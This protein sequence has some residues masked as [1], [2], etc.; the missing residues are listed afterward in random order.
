MTNP[1]QQIKDKREAIERQRVESKLK[2]DL[3]KQQKHQAMRVAEQQYGQMVMQVLE[4]LKEA[5]YPSCYS[6]AK[7]DIFPISWQIGCSQSL[8]NRDGN[9]YSNWE[10]VAC[11]SLEYNEQ[12]QRISF[13]CWRKCKEDVTSGLTETELV[14]ALQRLYSH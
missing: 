13:N 7:S 4:Q 8:V 11:I 3:L 2:A 10:A 1:F 6:V 14:A 12:N 5:A 9:Q